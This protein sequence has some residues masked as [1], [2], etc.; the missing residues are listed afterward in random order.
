MIAWNEIVKNYGSIRALAGFTLSANAGEVVGLLGPN[1]A[2]KTTALRVAVGLARADSGDVTIAGRSPHDP[3]SR[4]DAGYVPEELPFPARIRTGEWLRAQLALRNGDPDAARSGA[5]KL[6]IAGAWERPLRSLSKG[7]RRRAGLS[8][9]AAWDPGLWI[10]DE[11]TA[12]LDVAGRE[13][14]EGI[15]IEARDRGR[16]VIVSSHVLS[17]VERVCDRVALVRAGS[18]EETGTPASF[19]SAPFVLEVRCAGT[20]TLPDTFVAIGGGRYRA[21]VA[22]REESN[23]VIASV[24]TENEAGA[25]LESVLR[26]A[27]LRDAIGGKF[28]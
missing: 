1:G 10:L 2:G 26:A 22:S 12:D 28:R 21:F 17:E 9:L 11:P 8:L 13:I 15:L 20:P 23:R 25:I 5:E 4:I 16:A 19:L 18:V 3:L 6:D 27:T 24:E 7:M 14:V